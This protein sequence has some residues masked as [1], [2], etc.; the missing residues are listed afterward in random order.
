[1][2]AVDE[3]LADRDVVFTPPR[4][5]QPGSDPEFILSI[6][7]VCFDY[8][9]TS[10][11]RL[12]ESITALLQETLT[13]RNLENVLV[14]GNPSRSGGADDSEYNINVYRGGFDRLLNIER[15][16]G[17]VKKC[18]LHVAGVVVARC[19][20][21][22]GPALRA[23]RNMLK[24]AWDTF[25]GRQKTPALAAWTQD[26]VRWQEWRKRRAAADLKTGKGYAVALK[27]TLGNLKRSQK[28]ELAVRGVAFLSRSNA[29]G[30]VHVCPRC[31]CAR[32]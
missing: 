5:K 20:N 24:E 21:S 2:T 27:K 31:V 1:M 25:E 14:V 7:A 19:R 13:R 18:V 8:I 15:L 17:P 29:V 10:D 16:G 30:S 4:P 3:L 6:F 23:L 26:R 32:V 9:T 12:R 28:E 22:V 11:P